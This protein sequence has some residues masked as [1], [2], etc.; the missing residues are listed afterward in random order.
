[1][2]PGRGPGRGRV[3]DDG[4]RLPVLDAKFAAPRLPPDVIPRPRLARQLARPDWRVAVIT[5]GPGAGKTVVASQQFEAMAGTRRAWITLDSADDHPE[6]FW[7]HVGSALRRA[8]PEHFVGRDLFPPV[9]RRD[10][11][12]SSAAD[13]MMNAASVEESLLIVFD[14]LDRIRNPSILGDIEALVEQLP[15]G[16]QLIVTSRVDPPLPVASWRAHSWLVE[17]RQ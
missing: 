2:D 7:L 8:V 14:Q 3:A 1:M 5:G 17:L 9:Y 12:G 13:L 6:R 10:R 16:L 11:R 15:I 4:E